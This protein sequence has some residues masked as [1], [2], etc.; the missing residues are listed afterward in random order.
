MTKSMKRIHRVVLKRMYDESPDTSWL[1]EYGSHID[2]PYTIDRKHATDCPAQE[3]NRQSDVLNQIER[4]ISYLNSLTYGN[5]NEQECSDIQDAQ[6]LLIDAQDAAL[7]CTCGERCLVRNS[8]RYFNP[9]WQNYKGLERAKIVKYC[10][11]DFERM[12]SLVAG[13]FCFI[14]IRAEAEVSVGRNGKP[15]SGYLLQEI[16]SGG[17]WGIESDSDASYLSEVEQEELSE[18]KTQLHAIG[19]SERAISAAFRNVE[20][21]QE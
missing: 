4:V 14:G 12:E 6:D 3:F 8:Y 2:S 19:F 16:T 15:D 1:G 11:Q 10:I 18:L 20:H 21:A 5:L 17:L 7:E 13:N 9:N